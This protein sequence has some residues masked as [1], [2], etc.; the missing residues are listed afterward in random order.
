MKKFNTMLIRIIITTVLFITV[1]VIKI[2]VKWYDYVYLAIYLCIYLIIGYDL[3]LKAFR[4][5]IR[6]RVFDENFLMAIATIGAFILGE[7]AEGVAVML[8]YQIGELF[9]SYAVDSSRKSI[10]ELMDI[11]PRTARIIKDGKTIVVSPEEINIGDVILTLSGE[12]IP[13]DGIVISREGSLDTSPLTG[14]SIPKH[15]MEGDN[16]LSGF[17]NTGGQLLIKAEKIYEDSAVAKILD[18]VEN[19]YAR[20]AK[21]EKFITKFAS[22]YTPIVVLSALML[23]LIPPLFAGEWTKW[24]Y[25]ALAFLVVSCPCALV[26]SV[27]LSFF[28]GIGASSRHGIL[29]KGGNYIEKL[30]KVNIFVFDK[31]GTLTKGEFEVQKIMPKDAQNEILTCAAIAESGSLHPVANAILRAYPDKIE[32][33]DYEI[34]EISGRGVIAKNNDMLIIIGNDA[35]MKENNIEYTVPDF[36]GSIVHVAKNNLYLG[37]IGVSDKIKE[38]SL[39]ALEALRNYRAETI[40][41]TGDSIAAAKD[42]AEKLKINSY[43]SNLLPDDKVK[44]LEDIME[45]KDKGGAVAFVGDGIND[46]PVIMRADVG[47]AMGGIGSDSAIEAADVVLMSDNLNLIPL[48]KKIA[49]KTMKIVRQNIIFAIGIKI[50]VLA[51]SAL[52]YAGIWSA[53][54][55]DVGVAMLAI[56]NSFRA[57]K[58]KKEKIA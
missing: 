26:I 43:Y 15:I 4:N 58:V 19:A 36:I 7:Y 8:F 32:N 20:K 55:A 28:G 54:F 42:T 16:V 46:A 48:A 30:E 29:I 24:A 44:I 39:S 49:A 10:A 51:L 22:I 21:S 45:N 23:A 37:W 2:F 40:M 41:L 11:K 9:Q 5:I 3:L 1:V 38:D 13:V 56:L 52:G 31:T 25:R 34:K 18:L 6:G 50:A 12:R 53:V 33:K 14:E 17:I 35:F 47:I 27:P 57:G